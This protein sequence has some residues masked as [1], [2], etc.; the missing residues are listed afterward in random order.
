MDDRMMRSIG[1]CFLEF[2][3]LLISTLYVFFTVPTPFSIT[4]MVLN[5]LFTLS[6]SSLL[7]RWVWRK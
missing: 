6:F 2:F 7:V 3:W 1:L 5:G 4:I